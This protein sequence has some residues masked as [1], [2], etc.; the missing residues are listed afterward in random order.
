MRKGLKINVWYLDDRTLCGSVSDLCSA[1]AIIEE[2]GPARGSNISR[3]KSLLCIPGDYSFNHNPLPKDIS[4]TC[5]RF[6]LLGS[7]INPPSFCEEIVRQRL[8]KIQNINSVL[9]PD[10]Q[11]S[12]MDTAVVHSYLAF[13]KVSLLFHCC[14]PSYIQEAVNC[15]R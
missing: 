13:P 7:P 14:L 9:L 10:L 12:L 15:F 8:K 5:M 4:N 3:E 6:V 11:D 1:L 2:E